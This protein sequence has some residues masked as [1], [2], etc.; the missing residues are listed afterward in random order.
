[1]SQ[2]SGRGLARRAFVEMNLGTP[3]PAMDGLVQVLSFLGFG[4]KAVVYTR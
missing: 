3:Q 1:M 2:N 4:I